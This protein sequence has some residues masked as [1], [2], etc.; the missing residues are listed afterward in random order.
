M[1]WSSEGP[2]DEY[3]LLPFL[4]AIPSPT[5]PFS[6]HPQI[7]S[8]FTHKVLQT[9]FKSPPSS[10]NHHPPKPPQN[11]HFQNPQR[12]TI[13]PSHLKTSTF[14]TLKEPPST[15]A[16]SKHPISKPSKN[17]HPPKPPQ[18]IH[19]QNPQRTTIH[20][21]HL[22]TSNFKTLKVLHFLPIFFYFSIFSSSTFFLPSTLSCSYLSKASCRL[23]FPWHK[24]PVMLKM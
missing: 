6:F 22:K 10:K 11:I 1:F 18:N 12:T 2:T 3:L 8:H 20:P 14:K 16:T 9:T 21:S 5:N 24:M 7:P 13:H 4:A 19:F 15:Q 23:F 17:H